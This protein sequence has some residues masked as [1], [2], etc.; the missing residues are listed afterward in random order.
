MKPEDNQPDML[1][2]DIWAHQSHN[3]TSASAQPF[4]VLSF[5]KEISVEV[6]VCLLFGAFDPSVPVLVV[7]P[8]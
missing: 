2:P 4:W 3:L 1:E 7:R 5:R 6:C 8:P